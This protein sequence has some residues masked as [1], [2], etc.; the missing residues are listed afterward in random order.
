MKKE[1]YIISS[2]LIMMLSI[3]F[4]SAGFFDFFKD[5][6]L[7]PSQETNV[8][9]IVGNT[10]PTIVSVNPI[11][12]VNLLAGT[13]TNVIVIFTAE[14]VNGATDLN[15]ATASASFSR[16]GETT[17]TSIPL[18]G[19]V[20]GAPSGNQITYTCTVTM[21]Y[22]DDNGPWTVTV[23]VNDQASATATNNLN[24]VTINLLRDII[25]S[26]S[27]INFPATSPGA[28]SVGSS[29]DTTITNLGNFNTPTD[30]SVDITAADLTG[31]VTPS[32]LIPAINFR[33]ADIA[34]LATRCSTGGSALINAAAVGIN[35][36]VLPRGVGGSNTGTLTYCITTV[37]L[38]ISSQGYTATIGTNPW[39]I[40]I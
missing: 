24:T 21:Q 19:C 8:S 18:T 34:D 38:G 5:I 27:L 12:A 28:T 25:I 7:A 15:S 40:G 4:V 17:R 23:S 13:T 39:T 22:Y 9:V 33:A 30:G 20:A 37:P 6:Q 16:A 26:P 36:A 32:E 29:V 11:P 14:D 1:M 10:P 31:T 2:I 3:S 35:G